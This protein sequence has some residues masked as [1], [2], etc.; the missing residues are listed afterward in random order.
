MFK[1]PNYIVH[2]KPLCSTIEHTFQLPGHTFLLCD[3]DFGVIEKKKRKPAAV[4][5]PEGWFTLV[6]KARVKHIQSCGHDTK[7]YLCGHSSN[8]READL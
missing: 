6:E 3:M 4:Y 2:V 5:N 8:E 1:K 7:I